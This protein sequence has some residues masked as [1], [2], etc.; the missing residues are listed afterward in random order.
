MAMPP[1]RFKD[2]P[3]KRVEVSSLIE[4]DTYYVLTEKGERYGSGQLRGNEILQVGAHL[5]LGDMRSMDATERLAAI[6]AHVRGTA[7]ID[8]T[9]PSVSTTPSVSTEP[10]PAPVEVAAPSSTAQATGIGSAIEAMLASVLDENKVRAIATE[11]AEKVAERA[12]DADT[13]VTMIDDAI[14]SLRPVVV[15]VGDRPEV[16]VSGRPHEKLGEVVDIMAAGFNVWMVGPMGTG[17]SYLARQAAEAM[18]TECFATSF[19]AQ[20]SKGDVFGYVIPGTGEVVRTPF[21]DAWELGGVFLADEI[22]AANPQ[23]LV[24]LNDAAASKPGAVLRFP[25]GDIARHD[26]FRMIGAA[27]TWGT[28]PTAEYVGRLPIDAATRDRFF[29]VEV[30]YDRGLEESLTTAH[31]NGS[32][33]TFLASVWR[34]RDN[35]TE[36]RVHVA[37]STRGVVEAA[38]MIARGWEVERAVD[39]RMLGGISADQRAKV[40]AGVSF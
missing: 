26:D 11:A 22:D 17:K 27:N 23:V 33:A 38:A 18:G 15:K 37:V 30:D 10:E 3:I 21:R 5:E 13:L 6:L 40:L 39:A 28:G 16:N 20:S 2:D 4:G 24:M 32:A 36:H 12:V 31:L 19:G 8:A 9:I 29:T 25:D 7:I 35:A 1:S 14:K 34:M